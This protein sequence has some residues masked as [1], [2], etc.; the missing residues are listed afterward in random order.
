MSALRFDVFSAWL[1]FPRIF[2][3][4][5]HLHFPSL[6]RVFLQV[7]IGCDSAL[8]R[9]G[10]PLWTLKDHLHP[11][12]QLDSGP[13]ERVP[14]LLQL[15]L[16]PLGF[17][18]LLR[19]PQWWPQLWPPHHHSAFSRCLEPPKASGLPIYSS[20]I[21]FEGYNNFLYR[22]EKNQGSLWNFF[23][24]VNY[25]RLANIIIETFLDLPIY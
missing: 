19:Q 23:E 13:L 2:G 25:W 6:G 10:A 7:E 18:S 1:F 5:K 9:F 16:L 20:I 4:F 15:S 21:L 3:A 17:R 11:N 22:N 12:R 14:D 8:T 24:G